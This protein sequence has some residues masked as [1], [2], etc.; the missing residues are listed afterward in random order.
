MSNEALLKPRRLAFVANVAQGVTPPFHARALNVVNTGV[1]YVRIYA[2][3]ADAAADSDYLE[4]AVGYDRSFP[5]PEGVMY[6]PGEI[7]CYAK[8][9][10]NG[11]ITFLWV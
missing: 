4:I 11:T 3:A 8:T 2:T 5:L 10:Q 6:R 1:D 7:A 9:P